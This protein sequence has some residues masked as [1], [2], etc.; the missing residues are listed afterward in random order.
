MLKFKWYQRTS[1]VL[2][3]A[4][5]MAGASAQA[6]RYRVGEDAFGSVRAQKIDTD[7]PVD[8]TVPVN[9]G[10]QTEQPIPASKPSYAATPPQDVSKSSEPETLEQ[11]PGFYSPSVDEL[12]EGAIDEAASTVTIRDELPSQRAPSQG[13]RKLSVFERVYLETE[14]SDAEQARKLRERWEGGETV[15]ATVVNESDFVDGDELLERGIVSDGQQPY[16][17]TY[18][19]E[20]RP[21]VS[22]VDSEQVSAALDAQAAEGD[23]TFTEVT[24]YKASLDAE[25]SEM[26]AGADQAA[27]SILGVGGKSYFKRY[28]ESCCAALPHARI[29][30][31][32]AGVAHFFKITKD[33]APFRFEDGDSRYLLLK[34]PSSRRNYPMR[35]RSFVRSFDE[36]GISHG[37]FL[38][39]IV[40]LNEE[41]QP[42]RILAE[43]LLR[44][45]EENWVKY[46]YLEGVFQ[47]EQNADDALDERFVL[48]NSTF[49]SR[50]RVTEVEEEGRDVAIKHMP[51]GSFEIEILIDEG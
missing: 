38:P 12:D 5:A 15:D 1:L 20:G 37:V 44:F 17:V 26:L 50:S 47:V 21:V 35:L 9:P 49:S 28:T 34:L 2:S 40:F 22:F 4:L 8:V 24:E 48:I 43:P 33:D 30:V 10:V 6:E 27:L 51:V 23:L 41:K 42:V 16:Q 11:V 39:Q 18:D 36:Q 7:E 13:K 45:E 14:V 32:E 3:V 46:G 29:P 25:R 19:A 31:I